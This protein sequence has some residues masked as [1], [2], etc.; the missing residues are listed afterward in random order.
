MSDSPSS[1]IWQKIMSRAEE[2]NSA[3]TALHAC[4]ACKDVVGATGVGFSLTARSGQREPLTATDPRTA[5]LEELQFTLGQGPS[6]DAASKGRLVLVPDLSAPGAARQW[7]LFAPAAVQRG[8]RAAFAFPVSSG[9][10]RL[11]ILDVYR[12]L[13]GSLSPD[14]LKDALAF[15][16]AVLVLTIDAHVGIADRLVHLG[17]SVGERHMDVHRAAGMV[18]EQLDISVA[19]ALVRLRAYAFSNDRPLN[20]V[21]VEVVSRRMRFAPDENGQTR[22][23]SNESSNEPPRPASDNGEAGNQA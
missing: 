22:P 8:I 19:D 12:E 16:D 20:D 15:A 9:A 21:A 4:V 5:E 3:P 18:S 10:I 11:G 13:S 6:A 7:P 2:D 14:E 23:G 17:G 1:R